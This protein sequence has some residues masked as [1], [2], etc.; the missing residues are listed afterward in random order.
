MAP[1]NINV[2][3]VT[4]CHDLDWWIFL[5]DT[6]PLIPTLI[7]MVYKEFL[8]LWNFYSFVSWYAFFFAPLQAPK[9]FS[10]LVYVPY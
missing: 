5:S 6:I 9:Q 10:E 1:P 7:L 4:L 8:Q 3:N 2:K